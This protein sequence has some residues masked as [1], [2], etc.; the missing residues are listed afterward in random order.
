MVKMQM[1][2]Q[3]ICVGPRSH[4]SNKLQMVVILLAHGLFEEQWFKYQGYKF[5]VH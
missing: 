5:L 1:L 3:Q 2:T 4:I